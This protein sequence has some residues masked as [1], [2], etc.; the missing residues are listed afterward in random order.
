L[1][2]AV[3]EENEAKE[4]RKKRKKKEEKER[5]KERRKGRREQKKR[6]R[7]RERERERRERAG[8]LVDGQATMSSSSEIA[9]CIPLN[10]ISRKMI[11]KYIRR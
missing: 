11:R 1:I 9:F 2:S 3:K 6:E 5:R 4:E 10:R 8:V 7:E